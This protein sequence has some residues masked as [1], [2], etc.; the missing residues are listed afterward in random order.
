MMCLISLAF[1][2]VFCRTVNITGIILDRTYPVD[3]IACTQVTRMQGMRCVCAPYSFLTLTFILNSIILYGIGRLQEGEQS[4]RTVY[5]S[6][7]Q[8]QVGHRAMQP[9]HGID[10]HSQVVHT[11][12]P[13]KVNMESQSMNEWI[14]PVRHFKY[15]NKHPVVYCYLLKNY[16]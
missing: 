11:P 2:A 8:Y 13:M 16:N 1:I 3:T 4:T 12:P 7:Y 15:N 9:Q 10:S 6:E 5:D 14:H